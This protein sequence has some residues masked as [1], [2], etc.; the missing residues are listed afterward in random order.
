[1]WRRFALVLRVSSISLNDRL[2][3]SVSVFVVLHWNGKD[4]KRRD[5]SGRSRNS[6][7]MSRC[8]ALT[9][10]PVSKATRASQSD[11]RDV[12]SLFLL[13]FL[14]TDDFIFCGLR[15]VEIRKVQKTGDLSYMDNHGWA[16][17]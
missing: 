16:G 13:E 9:G 8:A 11:D 14:S 4:Y 1:M 17:S 12:S 2:R 10:C 5:S 7:A 6:S 15:E 3:S